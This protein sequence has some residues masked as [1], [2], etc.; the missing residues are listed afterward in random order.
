MRKEWRRPVRLSEFVHKSC[1]GVELCQKLGW[2]GARFLRL[3]C[4]IEI[5][6]FSGKRLSHCLGLERYIRFAFKDTHFRVH[7]CCSTSPPIFS[8]ALTKALTSRSISL[9]KSSIDGG[10][11]SGGG[12]SAGEAVEEGFTGGAAELEM[13]AIVDECEESTDVAISSS[14]DVAA[15]SLRYIPVSVDIGAAIDLSMIG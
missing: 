13:A 8:L 6:P 7:A 14:L 15:S 2:L 4:H 5:C 11:G 10:R 3:C 12:A 9:S 1:A